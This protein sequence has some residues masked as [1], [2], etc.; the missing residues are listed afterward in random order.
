M[1]TAGFGF[2]GGDRRAAS[3]EGQ[4]TE[5]PLRWG[6]PCFTLIWTGE[7]PSFPSTGCRIFSRP[8]SCRGLKTAPLPVNPW[9]GFEF[10]KNRKWLGWMKFALIC[11]C[12]GAFLGL[13]VLLVGMDPCKPSLVSSRSN[14]TC[15]LIKDVYCTFILLLKSRSL[16]KKLLHEVNFKFT[17]YGFWVFAI[18][19][20]WL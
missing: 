20:I 2:A 6:N 14:H 12:S 10:F 16:I 19:L 5:T 17:F 13:Q 15:Y 1:R 18:L 8:V 7:W 3:C 9:S 4:Q 11:D